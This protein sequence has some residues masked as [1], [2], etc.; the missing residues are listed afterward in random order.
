LSSEIEYPASPQK[1][2]QKLPSIKVS[3]IGTSM[4]KSSLFLTD[5]GLGSPPKSQHPKTVASNRP[6]Q[7]YLDSLVSTAA[8]PSRGDNQRISKIER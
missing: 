6:T 4:E 3:N 1:N 7:L 8:S 2:L 5:I